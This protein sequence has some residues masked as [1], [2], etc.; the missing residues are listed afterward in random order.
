MDSYITAIRQK[1][2]KT[3]CGRFV[4]LDKYGRALCGDRLGRLVRSSRGSPWTLHLL[5]NIGDLALGAERK[6]AP[7]LRPRRERPPAVGLR[8][9]MPAPPPQ[10]S[11]RGG[12]SFVVP[13]EEGARAHDRF[14]GRRVAGVAAGKTRFHFGGPRDPE[15]R[16]QAKFSKK[17]P[18]SGRQECPVGVL[19]R[20]SPGRDGPGVR[21]TPPR[22]YWPS[23][24]GV[25][26]CVSKD[27]PP[28][29]SKP[30]SGL[31]TTGGR[32]VEG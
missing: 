11:K 14:P 7:G 22:A 4:L 24:S 25:D 23:G 13:V 28:V 3:I 29:S 17:A 2:P 31:R 1:G 27:A 26:P 8:G 20:N 15:C 6:R 19:R 9:V 30:R 18:P 32:N 5:P 21:V 16:V 12:N 10:D